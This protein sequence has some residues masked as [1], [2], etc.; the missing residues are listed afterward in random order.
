MTT[1]R[2]TVIK[3][4]LDLPP[5]IDRRTFIDAFATDTR[6]MGVL[7]VCIHWELEKNEIPEDFYQ[8]FYLDAEEYALENYVSVR[9]NNPEE[10]HKVERTLIGGLGGTKVSLTERECKI[11]LQHF[12]EMNKRLKLPLPDKYDEYSFLLEEDAETLPQEMTN[13][14]QKICTPITND[15]QLVHYFLMRVFGKDPYAAK[16]LASPKVDLSIYDD[17]PAATLC[18]NVVDIDHSAFMDTYITES[19]VEL[20]NSYGIAISKVELDGRKRVIGFE[21]INFFKVSAAE[22]AMQLARP[23]FMTIYTLL[24]DPTEFEIR[25]GSLIDRAI[26]TQHASGNL[27][28]VFNENNDHVK[29]KVYKLN[30]DVNGFMYITASGQLLTVAYSLDGIHKMER[31]IRRSPIAGGAFP[32]AK[33]E[34]KEP[35]LF[36]FI[37]SEFDDFNEFL[38][39]IKADEDE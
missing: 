2:F 21:R 36:D 30:E 17:V 32:I 6:L 28:M 34:F 23:E 3:G 25:C 20:N 22:A 38:D 10:L 14:M 26:L 12:A 35:V 31:E 13:I 8:Y 4:G 24:F 27:Y 19:L 15:Y 9:G 5:D 18:K 7:G 16:Y 1:Q 39:C 29:N 33:Y 11:L 37:Q